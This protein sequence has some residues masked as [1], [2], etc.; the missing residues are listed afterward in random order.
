MT[1]AKQT[2]EGAIRS[3]FPGKSNTGLRAAIRSAA[4]NGTLASIASRIA[5]TASGEAGLRAVMDAIEANKKTYRL[6]DDG[7]SETTTASSMAE[8]K[9]LAAASWENGNWEGGKAIISVQVA[10][11]DDAGKAVE[12][13]WVDVTVGEDPEAPECSC[14]DGHEFIADVN[15]V[16]GLTE[17]PGVWSQGGTTIVTKT[18]CKHCGVYQRETSY[19]SQRNPGQCDTVEYLDADES[20]IAWVESLES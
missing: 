15:V 16:G 8:A 17:N 4:Q 2:V 12:I 19:G 9:W 18:C 5:L 20:S 14:E 7:Y 11:L 10:E 1:I 13:D 3:N 6:S